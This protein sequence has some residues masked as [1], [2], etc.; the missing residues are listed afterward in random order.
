MPAPSQDIT[1]DSNDTHTTATA[2]G[3]KDDGWDSN[4][5]PSSDEMNYWMMGV[6]LWIAYLKQRDSTAL[7]LLAIDGV[8]S[9]STANTGYFAS[10][11]FTA[12]DIADVLE[13]PLPV[14]P[15]G[16]ITEVKGFVTDSAVATFS[17]DMKL[18]K[19]DITSTASATQIGST[20]TS[21]GGGGSTPTQTLTIGSLNETVAANTRYYLTFTPHAGS[22][23]FGTIERVFG[24]EVTRDIPAI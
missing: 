16:H 1:W 17:W 2:A 10:G 4:E 9:Y 5:V 18:W 19:R 15:G 7:P 24:A 6:Y 22:T 11:I 3:H 13:I 14:D 8:V 12:Q 20:Q 21:S 23:T